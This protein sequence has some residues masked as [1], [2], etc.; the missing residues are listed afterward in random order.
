MLGR[1][2]E[3]RTAIESL[4]KYNPTFL[5]LEN[6]REDIEM[7][8]PDKDEVEQFLQGLQKAGLKY[9]SA[10]SAATGG[11]TQTEKRSYGLL[12]GE[13]RTL[14]SAMI[15]KPYLGITSDRP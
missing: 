12:P 9:G 4:R 8:D 7:W 1:H 13:P 5:N 10:N 3:A 6:V 2:E 11:R 14:D 15:G